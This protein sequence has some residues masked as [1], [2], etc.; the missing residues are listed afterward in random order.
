VNRIV[1]SLHVGRD[2]TLLESIE[3]QPPGP[4]ADP[5]DAAVAYAEA[6]ADEIAFIAS[7]APLETLVALARRVAP[8]LHVPFWIKADLLDRSEVGAVLDAGAARVAVETPALRDPDYITALTRAF[9]SEA[10]AIVVTA[11]R[12]GDAWR[13]LEMREGAPT[14]WDAIA[15]ARVAETQGAGELVVESVSGGRYEEPFDLELLAAVKSAV[16]VPVVAAGEAEA[17]EDLF[18]ALMIGGADAVLV[19]S[20]LH[21]GKGTVPDVKAFLAEHGLDVADGKLDQGP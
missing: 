16:A 4:L 12:E 5:L 15:W 8:R 13:V 2:G 17:V 3:L 1:A 7:E 19:G 20:L 21:S 9:G 10:V 14:E 6:G 11:L 18:D